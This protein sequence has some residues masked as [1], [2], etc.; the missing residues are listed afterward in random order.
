MRAQMLMFK[1]ILVKMGIYMPI[2]VTELPDIELPDIPPIPKCSKISS[3]Y[4]SAPPTYQHLHHT[5]IIKK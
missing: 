3:S 1:E 4:N 5:A 2:H